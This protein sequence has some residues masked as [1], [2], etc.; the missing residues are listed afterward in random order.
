MRRNLLSSVTFWC[1]V[2]AIVV[3]GA[4]TLPVAVD[5]LRRGGDLLTGREFLIANQLETAGYGLYSY[6]L[7]ERA[8]AGNRR[9]NEAVLDAYLN[10]QEIERFTQAGVAR[11]QLNVNYLPLSEPPP[12]KPSVDWLLDHYD[13]TRAQIIARTAGVRVSGRPHIVSYISPIALGGAVDQKRLLSQD[14]STVPADLAF[15]WMRNFIRQA[16]RPQYWDKR[17]TMERFMLSLR[18][19]IAVVARAFSEVG[20]AQADVEKFFKSRITMHE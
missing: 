3:L 5:D 12:P 7:L 15:L 17:V 19:E 20:S 4:C 16:Q 1:G 8:P 2:I 18:T 13:Y 11:S 14:L 10:I 9:L 6:V